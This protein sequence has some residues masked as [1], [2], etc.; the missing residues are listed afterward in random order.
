MLPIPSPQV[1]GDKVEKVVTSKRLTDSPAIV[2][3]S[4]FGWSTNMER[5]ARAQVGGTAS[6]KAHFPLGRPWP[7]CDPSVASVTPDMLATPTPHTQSSLPI[8]RRWATSSRRSTCVAAAFWRSTP[9]AP[10]SSP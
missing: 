10:S 6:F 7:E 3:L 4:K 2:V 9:T 5:I 1:L 8:H